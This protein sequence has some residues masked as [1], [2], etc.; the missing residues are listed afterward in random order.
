MKCLICGQEFKSLPDHLKKH[1]FSQKDYFDKFILKSEDEKICP[2]YQKNPKC[3]KYKK[4]LNLREGYS[5]YCG[6]S[7]ASLASNEKRKN[8]LLKKYGVTNGSQIPEAQEKRKQTYLSKHGVE[9]ISQLDE[10]KRK[11]RQTSRLHYGTDHPQQN[12]D[13][14]KKTQETNLEKYNHVCSLHNEKVREKVIQTNLKKSGFEHQ[15]KSIKSKQK[16][17]ETITSKRAPIIKRILLEKLDLELITPFKNNSSDIKV[18]CNKCNKVYETTYFNLYQCP[19][20][21][22]DCYPRESGT[23]KQ[24][25]EI[26]SFIKKIYEGNVYQNYRLY[27][28][29]TKFIELDVFIPDKNLAIEYNGLYWHSEKFKPKDYH[30]H[31]LEVCNENNINLIQIFEDEWLIKY[32]I[33]KSR[34]KHMLGVGDI[35]KVHA[36]KCV[37]EEIDAK[38]K[39]DFLNK[40]HIQGVDKSVV[41]LGAFYGGTLVSV[42]TFSKGS[43]SKGSRAKNGVWELS[44]FCSD[45]KYHIPGIA[46]K[47][48]E[49]FKRNYNWI[50]IFS[51]ADRRWS[52][53]NVYEKLGFKLDSVTKPNYWYIKNFQRVHRFNLRKKSSEPKDIPEYILRLAEGYER[54]WDCGNLKYVL[55]KI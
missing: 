20:P 1:N 41:K 12:P 53:G 38:T 33:V 31:K 48:L 36:R 3:K 47:L 29:N 43:I 51:Y 5:K 21:C 39:N 46:S 49:Y 37:I 4:F 13:I 34:L 40:Y 28:T 54:V 52:N 44:R 30:L 32:N 25:K 27:Y 10:I 16:L 45:H 50:N 2:Y 24:E 8:T 15:M 17:Q 9:N 55:N 7:C 35:T 19:H 11:K 26:F 14:I 18:K 6:R 23:S 22:K 42:I